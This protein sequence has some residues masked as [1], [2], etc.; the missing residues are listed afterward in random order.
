MRVRRSELPR[1][2]GVSRQ[3]VH[4]DIRAGLYRPGHDGLLDLDE[5]RQ[6]RGC[7]DPFRGGRREAL[8]PAH[9]PRTPPRS[10]EPDRDALAVAAFRS[11]V[12]AAGRYLDARFRDP[13]AASWGTELRDLRHAAA[14]AVALFPAGPEPLRCHLYALAGL[15]QAIGDATDRMLEWLEAYEGNGGGP[16]A[17]IFPAEFGHFL[18]L[19]LVIWRG[20]FD[21]V[22]EGA[23]AG[24][25][26]DV[27]MGD[28]K[29][30]TLLPSA[31]DL[32][33]VRELF[34]FTLDELD[35][36]DAPEAD[37]KGKPRRR[38][39]KA[40]RPAGSHA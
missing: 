5:V 33:A 7:R 18:D 27:P 37:G 2:L 9:P 19:V 4:A 38:T 12:E 13:T 11:L 24:R 26:P 23:D 10:R 29:W 8:A 39:R 17:M 25:L 40:A 34:R 6:G 36:A 31:T 30:M 32:D 20:F 28:G 35:A 15:V 14:E 22:R 21:G 16:A 1:L 3:Q